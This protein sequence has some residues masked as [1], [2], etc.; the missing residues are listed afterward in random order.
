MEYGT[1]NNGFTL[2]ELVIV[3]VLLVI[4]LVV[5]AV[6]WPS[7]SIELEALA[8]QIA[9]DVRYTQALSMSHNERYRINFASNNYNIADSNGTAVK[10]PAAKSMLISLH[11]GIIF[12]HPPTPSCIAFNGKGVPC[13]CNDGS[14]LNNE[15]VQLAAGSATR[16]II[17]TETTGYVSINS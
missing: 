17:I 10:H 15:I 9:S 12:N 1:K 13:D 16:N 5:T 6:K 8:Y 4:I 3:L 14:L 11:N 7:K 2:V